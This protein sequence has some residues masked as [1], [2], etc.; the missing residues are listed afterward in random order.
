MVV[1]SLQRNRWGAVVTVWLLVC[2]FSN[3]ALAQGSTPATDADS[4]P[5]VPPALIREVSPYTRMSAYGLVGWH[6][7]KRELWAKAINQNYSSVATVEA[8][9]DAPKLH[10][11]IPSNVYDVY[12]SPQGTSLVYVKDTDGNELFQLYAYDLKSHKSSLVSDGK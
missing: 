5:T 6:P 1:L 2:V 8:P 11:F 10:T 9:A 7:S 12:Y 3:L 4:V